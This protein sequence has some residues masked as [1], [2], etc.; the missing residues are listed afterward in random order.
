MTIFVKLPPNGG[1]L[2]ITGKFFKTCR[3]PLFRGF[4]VFF[5]YFFYLETEW[6]IYYDLREKKKYDV[7]GLKWHYYVNFSNN[8]YLVITL[9]FSNNTN[10]SNNNFSNNIL[11]ITWKGAAISINISSK[12]PLVI[13]SSV[14][15]PTYK[16]AIKAKADIKNLI[17]Q[18]RLFS[19]SKKICLNRH[20]F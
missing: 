13:T 14:Q 1:H 3:C 6:N 10:F 12:R 5:L 4:N 8:T 17:L 16:V 7:R 11:V 18:W 15:L 9:T 20:L 2:L 19:C